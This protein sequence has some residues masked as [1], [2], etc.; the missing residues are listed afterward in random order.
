[1]LSSGCPTSRETPPLGRLPP[2][3]PAVPEPGR[4]EVPVRAR[5]TSRT[6]RPSPKV[7]TTGIYRL[8]VSW[9]PFD[10]VRSERPAMPLS[11][12]SFLTGTVATGV[13]LAGSTALRASAAPAAT[14]T[15]L[16]NRAPLRPAAFLRLPPGAIKAARLARHPT[17]QAGR[18][19]QRPVPG[20]VALPGVR[21]HRVDQPGPRRLG[22]TPYW[23][24]GYG[25][26]GYV[27]GDQRVIADAQRWVDGV[28]GTGK[29]TGSSARPR[30][31]PRSTATP[32]CGRTCRCCTPCA[33]TPSTRATAGSCPS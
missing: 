29:R 24:R 9:L 5:T 30:C 28:L 16:A 1:M 4:T 11:R 25:D 7:L 26:L 13:A 33:R 31:A 23:L 19:A 27:T 15:Y 10:F 17:G 2:T 14:T 18:R 21:R 6:S 20:Q 12:R 32:T 3:Q 22:G 8:I